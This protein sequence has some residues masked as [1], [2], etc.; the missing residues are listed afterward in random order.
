MERRCVVAL[1]AHPDDAELLCGGTLIRLVRHGW[2]VHIATLSSGDCGSVEESP[3]AIARRRIAEAMAA[4][5]RLGGT[6]HYLGGQDLQL[7]DSPSLRAAAVALLRQLDP[8]LVITHFPI[9]YMPDH[10]ATSAVARAAVF[11]AP[12]P[13]YGI[14]PASSQ[15]ATARM[16]HLVYFGSPMGG[17]DYV[18]TPIHPQFCVDISEVFEEKASVLACHASQRDWLRRHHGMDHYLDEMRAWDARMGAL[19][20]V[21][22]AEGFTPHRGHAYPQTPVLQSLLGGVAVTP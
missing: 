22:Y 17:I 10:E 3:G 15:P 11:T 4:A 20:G 12:I 5:A 16:A 8:D 1:C 21:P 6:Y 7:F 13:N 14:G 18:G 2:S 9:D 19:I